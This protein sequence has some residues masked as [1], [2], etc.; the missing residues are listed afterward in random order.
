MT[1]RFSITVQEQFAGTLGG[2]ERRTTAAR[3]TW[4]RDGGIDRPYG[5][6]NIGN[7]SSHG[8]GRSVPRRFLRAADEIT[9]DRLTDALLAN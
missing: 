9:N 6:A 5:A 1:E 4:G 2:Y 8:P 3:S 7:R